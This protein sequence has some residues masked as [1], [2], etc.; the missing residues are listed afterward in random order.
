MKIQLL[1]YLLDFTHIIAAVLASWRLTELFTADRLTE[2]LR[3]R[4]KHVYVFSCLRCMSVWTGIVATLIF[5]AFPWLNWPLALSWMYIVHIDNMIARKKIAD[6]RKFTVKV[7]FLGQMSIER[8]ELNQ[9]EIE[10]IANHMVAEIAKS[11]SSRPP[12]GS[13]MPTGGPQSPG[14]PNPGEVNA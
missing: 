1:P 11:K 9:Y 5:V 6:G 10:L 8:A 13:A 3:N 12:N 7:D 4:F 14:N 2:K